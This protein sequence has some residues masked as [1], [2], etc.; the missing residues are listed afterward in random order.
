MNIKDLHGYVRVIVFDNNNNI[1]RISEGYNTLV[2]EGRAILGD[3]LI[4]VANNTISAMNVGSSAQL[5]SENDTDL[6]QPA[7]PIERI[8]I[9]IGGKIRSNLTLSFSV[10]IPSNKYTRPLTIREV[11]V[12]FDPI[13]NGKMFARAVIPDIIL[14]NNES[15]RIDYEIQL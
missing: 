5:P 4:G 12:Y 7:T 8:P 2:I 14:N 1:V 9:G 3:L 11:G 13:N 15:A 6:I 10:L